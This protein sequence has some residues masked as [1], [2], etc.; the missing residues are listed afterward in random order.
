MI[1]NT[2]F[3]AIRSILNGTKE[4]LQLYNTMKLF[5]Y[6]FELSSQDLVEI[7]IIENAMTRMRE[8]YINFW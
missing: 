8:K 3:E 4:G 1:I 5:M 6:F 7:D 2:D